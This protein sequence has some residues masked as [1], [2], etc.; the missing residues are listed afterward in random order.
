[1][2][3]GKVE[4]LVD[5]TICGVIGVALFVF[6]WKEFYQNDWEFWGFGIPFGGVIRDIWVLFGEWSRGWGDCAFD[7]V[8]LL[9]RV[10]IG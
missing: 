3:I 5:D 2:A 7:L 4:V 1:M 10:R 9:K 8:M 6:F